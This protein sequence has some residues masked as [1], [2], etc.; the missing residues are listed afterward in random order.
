MEL[1][2]YFLQGSFSLDHTFPVLRTAA[3]DWI[4]ERDLCRAHAIPVYVSGISAIVLVVHALASSLYTNRPPHPDLTNQHGRAPRAHHTS[5]AEA[6]GGNTIFFTEVLR[7]LGCLELLR[8]STAR[9]LAT[10]GLAAPALV[11]EC[12]TF[13]RDAACNLYK[14]N[15]NL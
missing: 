7:L 9:F 6:H 2:A 3:L 5:H 8:V 4:S 14:S 1:S 10:Q 15:I 13:V 11:L 12:I